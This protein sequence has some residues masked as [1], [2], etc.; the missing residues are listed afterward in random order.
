MQLLA[1]TAQHVEDG[2]DEEGATPMAGAHVDALS[3]P[4]HSNPSTDPDV[5]P[6]LLAERAVVSKHGRRINPRKGIPMHV[7]ATYAL[8]L[9]PNHEG[10]LTDMST[11]IE[12]N[13]LFCKQ[14]DWTP[15]PGTKTYPR[16]VAIFLVTFGHVVHTFEVTTVRRTLL[17][18]VQL[19]QHILPSKAC[20]T[21]CS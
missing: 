1:T 3:H 2:E 16:Y 12:E 5:E 10:N 20:H 15:R 4:I 9:L 18:R 11:V 21:L 17:V 6:E 7:M 13:G 8:Q 19:P 14:L